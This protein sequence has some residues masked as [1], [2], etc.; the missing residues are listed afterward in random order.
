MTRQQFRRSI[1]RKLGLLAALAAVGLMVGSTLAFHV[2]IGSVGFELDGNTD[3]GSAEGADWEDIFDAT[4][5]TIGAVPAAVGAQLDADFVK[6]FVIGASGPDASYHEPSNKDDQPVFA[7]GGSE[8][9]GCG[10]VKNATD[11]DDILNAYAIAYTGAAGTEDAGDLIV[12]FGVERFDDSG[13]AYLGFWLFQADVACDLATGKFTGSKTNNDILLL[14]NFSNGGSVVKINALAWHPGTPAASAAGTFTSIGTGVRCDITSDNNGTPGASAGSTNVDMCAITNGD[15]DPSDGI[16]EAQDVVVPWPTE[17]KTKPGAPNPDPINTLEPPEFVEGA[18]N[19]T[20]AFAAAPGSP[21]LP[22]C[23]GSF[24]AETRSSDTLSATLKDFA[25][26]DFNTCNASVSIAGTGTNRVG[27]EHTFTVTATQ[28]TGGGTG[29]A[30]N[31]HATVALTGSNGIAAADIDINEADSTC[32]DAGDNLD[33]SGQCVI[34]FVSNETGKITGHVSVDI[35]LGGGSILTRDTD[36][37]TT[38]IGAGPNGSETPA[39][40]T[41]VDATIDITGDGTNRVGANHQFTSTVKAD[42][43]NGLGMQPVGS[44]LV[45]I[46]KVDANGASSSPAGTQTCTTNSSGVCS[47]TFTSNATGTTTGTAS[48]TVTVGGISFGITTGADAET[49]GNESVLKTWVDAT[50]DITGD[51]TNRVNDPHLFTVTVKKDFGDGSG[52][53]NA[54]GQVVTVTLTDT[55]G[56]AAVVD[57]D[58]DTDT[59]CDDGT[60]S[61]GQCVVKFASASTGVTTGTASTTVTFGSLS[62]LVTTANDAATSANED[63][64]KGW[65]NARIGI[66]GDDTNSIEESHTFTVTVEKDPSASG[67]YVAAGGEDVDVTLTDGAGATHVLDTTATTCDV[68]ADSHDGA[69]TDTSGQCVVVFTSNSAGTVTASAS[70]SLT[71]ETVAMT[72]TTGDATSTTAATVL[73]TFLDGSI[74][75]L[76]HDGDGNLLGGATFLVCRTSRL[77]SDSG[78]YVAEDVDL[79]E[80]GNQPFCF[81]VRDND[82]VYTTDPYDSDPDAGELQVID[83]VLGQYNVTETLPPPGYHI[84]TTPG[85]GPFSFPDMTIDP[86]PPVTDVVLDTIFVNI[87]AFRIIVITCDDI[88]H[89]LVVSTVTLDPNGTPVTVDSMSASQLASWNLAHSQDLTEGQIC[90]GDVQLTVPSIGGSAS[91]GDLPDGTYDIQTVVPKAS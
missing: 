47:I 66:A 49:T 58:P 80:L 73:K 88:S 61:S 52:F 62:F 69:G 20:D 21:A 3:S 81:T 27:V 42:S 18:I 77:D 31:G 74:R 46:Q 40:K 39:V 29:P 53:V 43:G 30:T 17:D 15:P 59:T 13:T 75:W 7:A 41:Y 71:V 82:G 33:S 11:K 68:P 34:K 36:P 78:L 76:K 1:P 8:V 19:L 10:S 63:A 54:A 86:S 45:S 6:D 90:G 55:N 38:A 14:V 67:G 25:L 91:F 56:A 44:Q 22:A 2:G 83:L 79:V 16:P 5:A 48:A 87:K 89:E 60:N 9:W 84:G 37:A 24:M 28:S 85:A 64:T 51:D 26:G 72:V 32:D 65:V 57:D 12:D 4:G 35:N 50:I 23:F 70:S